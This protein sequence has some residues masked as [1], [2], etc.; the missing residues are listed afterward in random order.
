MAT[1]GEPTITFNGKNYNISDLSEEG[2][3]QVSNVQFTELE[4][5]RLQ[6]LTAV[7][8]TAL[9]LYHQALAKTLTENN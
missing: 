1:Q 6:N 8:Q 5:Q 4:I 7:A 9:Q 3:K 2:K